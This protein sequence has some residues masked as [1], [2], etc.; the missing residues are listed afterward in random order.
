MYH[1]DVNTTKYAE[2]I[3]EKPVRGRMRINTVI[4]VKGSNLKV[5]QAAILISRFLATAANSHRLS[6]WTHSFAI[7]AQG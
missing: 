1:S 3:L 7:P 6:V 4:L 2:L 5:S